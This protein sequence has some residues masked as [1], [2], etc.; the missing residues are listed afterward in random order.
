MQTTTSTPAA[1]ELRGLVKTFGLPGGEI[2]RAVDRI[3]LTISPGEVVAVLGP[4]GAGKTTALDMVLGLTTPSA[5]T[6]AVFGAEPRRAVM[7]GRV[8]AVL[9]TGGL[10]RDITVR[11][12]VQMIASTFPEHAAVEEVIDRA[13]LT[14]LARRK[15]SKCSGGEQQRLRFALALLPDPDLL[16]LDE[17]TAGMDV[18][19]RREFWDTMHADADA[20]RTVV[21]ATHYLEEADAFA[22]R[23]VMIA[24]GRVVADGPTAQIRSQATG[25]TVSA[26]LPHTGGA[27]ILARLR[28]MPQVKEATTQGH[29][30]TV[31]SG[32]SDAVAR[33]LLGELGATNLE[34][35]SGSLE[36]AFLTITAAPDRD[37]RTEAVPDR[38]TRT[39][40]VPDRNTRT[41]QEVAR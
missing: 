13:G 8:S 7:A 22:K 5:G 16:V 4:N 28:S 41:E 24:G 12:T 39:E 31:T 2:V 30:V 19:A 36:S 37:A 10:L 9:Q 17:P 38:N 35:A 29:R 25:R 15:V 6:V 34:I 21:F 33:A 3:G 26:D 14:A 1:I 27:H 20:G 32:D 23:I 40:A 18:S 11:E